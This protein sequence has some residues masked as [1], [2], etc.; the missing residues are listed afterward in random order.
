MKLPSNHL[1]IKRAVATQRAAFPG[2]KDC[3]PHW[4][5]LLWLKYANKTVT[6][7]GKMFEQKIRLI[8]FEK[9]TYSH[10]IWNKNNLKLQYFV[11][12]KFLR[13][14]P[15]CMRNIPESTYSWDEVCRQWPAQ[16]FTSQTWQCKINQGSDVYLAFFAFQFYALPKED[17]V[18]LLKVLGVNVYIKK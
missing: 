15:S 11:E 14:L 17:T 18:L 1:D 16:S 12:L 13:N 2:T 7:T 4:A 5:E 8:Q 9:G 10:F 3:M 6:K